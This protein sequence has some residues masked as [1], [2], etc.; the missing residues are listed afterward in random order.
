MLA[1]NWLLLTGSLPIKHY[2]HF[3]NNMPPLTKFFQTTNIPDW[4]IF[5]AALLN[6]M[7]TFEMSFLLHFTRF[8][9]IS[10]EQIWS[11]K[12]LKTLWYLL[13]LKKPKPSTSQQQS[14]S[15]TH[16]NYYE[17]RPNEAWLFISRSPV[18]IARQIPSTYQFD[19]CHRSERGHQIQHITTPPVWVGLF[20]KVSLTFTQQKLVNV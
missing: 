5:M 11:L 7:D 6:Q 4:L 18:C 17:I 10:A 12:S 19:P 1:I 3:L 9:Q 8:L 14:D 2:L 13:D 20:S 16:L 15:T